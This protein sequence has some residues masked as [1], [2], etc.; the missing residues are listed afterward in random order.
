[1]TLDT[2]IKQSEY[3]ITDVCPSIAGTA[4]EARLLET[5]SFR[6]REKAHFRTVWAFILNA[7]G[8]KY[9]EREADILTDT[10]ITNLFADKTLIHDLAH[11]TLPVAW[12]F[13]C[14][15]ASQG[16]AFEALLQIFARAVRTG[17]TDLLQQALS[18]KDEFVQAYTIVSFGE[19]YPAAIRT[20]LAAMPDNNPYRRLLRPYTE[21][22]GAISENRRKKDLSKLY[23]IYAHSKPRR[24]TVR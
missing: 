4:E 16:E 3:Q 17:D 21:K 7:I 2:F 23:R 6:L 10:A 11:L 12:L 1:M 15:E 22:T 13:R 8:E 5:F 9:R 19:A 20:I 18:Y 24:P 14:Y